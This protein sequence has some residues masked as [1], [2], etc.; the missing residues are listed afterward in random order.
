M[1]DDLHDIYNYSDECVGIKC[2]E[3]TT[4]S[5]STASS[6]LPKQERL[7]ENENKQNL[8]TTFPSRATASIGIRIQPPG[9]VLLVFR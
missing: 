8:T 2:G 3:I 7:I 4:V 9:I 6:V 1:H 5:S